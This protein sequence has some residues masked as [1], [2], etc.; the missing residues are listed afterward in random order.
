MCTVRILHLQYD[1]NAAE[2]IPL[3]VGSFETKISD[4]FHGFLS[5]APTRQMNKL[6][7][8]YAIPVSYL[9]HHVLP[10]YLGRV[11]PI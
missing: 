7:E 10:V 11:T 4:F 2:E 6:V 9:E 8:H 5:Q 3:L 1:V